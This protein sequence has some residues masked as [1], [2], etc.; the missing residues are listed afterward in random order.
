[1]K[2]ATVRGGVIGVTW[3]DEWVGS[4]GGRGHGGSGSWQIV[5]RDTDY[6]QEPH[7]P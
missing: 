5:K 6:V 2:L 3:L 1:M 7:R 4:D